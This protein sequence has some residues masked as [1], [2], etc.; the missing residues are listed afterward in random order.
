MQKVTFINARGES[1]EIC[2]TPFFLGNIEGLGDVDANIQTQKAP[3]QDGSTYINTFLDERSIPIEVVILKDFQ[4]NRQLLSRVFNPKL[5]PGT[6]VYENDITRREI[7][8]ISEHVPKFP[9]ERPRIVQRATIDL[10]C[11]EPYWTTEEQ[12]EQLVTWE[13]GLEFPLLLP[14][15]FA[16]QSTNNSKLLVNDGDVDTPIFITFEGPATAPIRITNLTTNEFIEVKHGL[17]AGEKLEI[18]TAFGKK[19]V[20]KVNT[21]GTRSNV[22]HLINLESTFFKLI[23]E[24]NRLKYSTGVDY[25]QAGVTIE[26]RNRYLGI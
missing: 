5:G 6:L 11:N 22:F 24:N 13:G 19:K 17:L 3:G 10:L 26:W 23:P 1:I 14:T 7:K 16:K 18:N 25:E 20:L 21:D 4:I 9:D 15:E 12:I 8:A 2:R